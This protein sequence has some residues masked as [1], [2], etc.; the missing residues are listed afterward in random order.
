MNHCDIVHLFFTHGTPSSYRYACFALK[1]ESCTANSTSRSQCIRRHRRCESGTIC[2]QIT[3][4]CILQSL[5]G[6]FKLDNI[7][8]GRRMAVEREIAGAGAS[9]PA[10]AIFDRS[11]H[12]LMYPT[13]LGIKGRVID[14]PRASWLMAHGSSDSASKTNRPS[15]SHIQPPG[16]CQIPSLDS[17]LAVL[18]APL[19]QPRCRRNL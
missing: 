12:M 14:T 6:T 16:T 17:F 4:L 11:G 15:S 10:T 7:D 9:A 3:V 19:E 18:I 8:F 5:D 13:M 1:Q 2:T